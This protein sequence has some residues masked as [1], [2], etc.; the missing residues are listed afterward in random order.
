MPSSISEQSESFNMLMINS[1]SFT[2][3]VDS[4][5]PSLISVDMFK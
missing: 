3:P 5:D 4:L 2:H 1:R